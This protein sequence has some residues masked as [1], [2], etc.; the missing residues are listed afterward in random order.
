M[1]LGDLPHWRKQA[2]PVEGAQNFAGASLARLFSLGL[3]ATLSPRRKPDACTPL[4]PGSWDDIGIPGWPMCPAI[5]RVAPRGP[6]EAPWGRWLA[7]GS[8]VFAV[9][10]QVAS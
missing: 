10:Q 5:T 4:L 7:C 3:L 1:V 9:S 8:S 6:L 2:S